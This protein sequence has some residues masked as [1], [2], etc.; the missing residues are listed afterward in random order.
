MRSNEQLCISA[1]A[2]SGSYANRLFVKS[3]ILHF[4]LLAMKYSIQAYCLKVQFHCD[5]FLSS[6]EKSLFKISFILYILTN[7][8]VHS[9]K[10]WIYSHWL[11][12][13]C[14]RNISCNFTL[15]PESTFFFFFQQSHWKLIELSKWDAK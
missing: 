12:I 15:I 7:T 8:S 13:N 10:N 6:S 9:N 14:N 5:S 4:K 3:I 1:N 2:F 11:K